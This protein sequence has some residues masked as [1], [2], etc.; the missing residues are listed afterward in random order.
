MQSR[1]LAMLAL[2]AVFGIALADA[3]SAMLPTWLWLGTGIAAL[4]FAWRGSTF[5][6][7]LTLTVVVFACRHSA[8]LDAT[9][10]HPL[11]HVLT[12]RATP[13]SVVAEGRIEKPLRR[14]LPGTE[15]GQAMFYA[16]KIAAP[17]DGLTWR[18]KSRLHLY[19]QRDTDLA[20]G[21][22]RIEGRLRLPPL[23]DNPGQFDQR[24]Q[25][26]RHGMVGELRA[27]S[28]Q[29]LAVD[30]WN[31]IAW[32]DHGAQRCREWMQVT[33]SAG[34]GNDDD[35]RKIILATV[36]GGAE[37]DA[38]ELE[39]PFRATGTLH[40]FAVSGLHVGII[41]WILWI[42]L[43][44]L[45]ASRA[46]MAIIVG[47]SLFGY[48]F[49]TGLR[50]STIR[51]AVMAAVLLS[52]EL[53]HR[54]SDVLNSLGAAALL[55][56]I[57]DTSQLFS[58]GFQFSFS[59]ITAIALLN[60]PLLNLQRPMTEHDPFMPE[61]LLNKMQR[62]ALHARRWLAGMIS[63]SAA[64]WIGSLPLTVRH[65]HLASPIALAANLVLVP[66]AFLILFTVVLVLLATLAHVPFAPVLLGNANWF[67][68]RSA[69]VIAQMFATIPGG[70]FFVDQ[71]SLILRAPAELTML[72]L[73][74]G[75]A[76][77]HLRVD[78]SH[79]LIDCGG[80]KDYEHLTRTYLQDAAV[81]RLQGLILSH[82]DYEHI[83]AAP[84]ITR[85]YKPERTFLS[86]LESTTNASRSGS[87][88]KLFA[89]GIKPSALS[90][91]DHLDFTNGVRAEI[92]YPPA[93]LRASRADDRALVI[94]LETGS[95]RI[96][97]CGDAGFLAEKHILEKLPAGSARCDVLI[98]NQHGSDVTMLPEFL[99][100]T[101]PRVII[102]SNNT[103][104]EGQKLPARIRNECIARKISLIDQAETGA[105]TLRIWPQRLEIVPFRGTSTTTLAPVQESV[106]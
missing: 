20:P 24:T 34:L 33:L 67:F 56:L 93:A 103:F 47:L 88:R 84:A 36:L 10:R 94:R 82:A 101:Q 25:D 52:G 23:P 71:P 87:L 18:G 42:L 35:A 72:R 77:H 83:G 97:L 59:V 70:N 106:R 2:A 89:L 28:I 45:G 60:R 1:P 15:P 79:W 58:I 13:L 17:Y 91:G 80:E 16:E 53:W 95:F 69:M 19:N 100:A 76:A 51:A 66:V 21:A 7:L 90:A 78:R 50:P 102:S 61:T 26:L 12:G 43:K 75:G 65:F 73:H 8:N 63:I 55:L 98:R 105:V 86:A 62:L 39:Q 3:L 11:F 68:A 37:A 99:N 38:R 46:T 22:Y 48:A 4:V 9:F 41:G 92:L 96:L 6:R 54:R 29:P 85:D 31:L 14:D 44:P 5:T 27:T 74:T 57:D 104:P 64:S 81:N 32:L 30:S 40:I 49:I